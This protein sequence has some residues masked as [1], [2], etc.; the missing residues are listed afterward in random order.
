[1]C[2]RHLR[3]WMSSR[4]S[5]GKSRTAW[6]CAKHFSGLSRIG[7]TAKRR[8]SHA[9]DMSTLLIHGGHVIDPKNGLDE[10]ADILVRDGKVAK[11]GKGIK[12]KADKDIDAKGL[13]VT[14]GLI[15]MHVHF[16]EP[17]REDKETL[18][19]GST[20]SMKGCSNAQWN[21][22]RHAGLW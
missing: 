12:E 21:T 9:N 3:R 15:D 11:V 8:S 2:T 18:E 10:V 16:R 1:M 4:I 20:Y 7:E 6:Q 19:T 17:G 5:C 22:Q 13:T 14:P